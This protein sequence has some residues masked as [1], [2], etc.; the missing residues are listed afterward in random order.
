MKKDILLIL[1]LIFT[2][3]LCIADDLSR[4]LIEEFDNAGVDLRL[5]RDEVL[6]AELKIFDGFVRDPERAFECGIKTVTGGKFEKGTIVFFNI[7][8]GGELRQIY[9]GHVVL[10]RRYKPFDPEQQ[11]DWKALFTAE[12]RKV[13][14]K[15]C[16][17]DGNLLKESEKKK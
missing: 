15:L 12:E 14:F 17:N 4:S 10:K 1:L 6:R 9:T 16:R 8:P 3:N 5:D 13:G 11:P 2:A 7:Q